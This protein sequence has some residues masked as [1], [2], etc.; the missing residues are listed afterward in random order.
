VKASELNEIV[1]KHG[2]WLLGEVGGT[3]ADLTGADLRGA[4]L[5]GADLRGAVL[6]G[7]VLRGADL[8]G[9]VLTRADLTGADLRGAD[10][11]GAVLTRAVL[12]RADLTG[13]DLTGADLTGADLRGADLRGAVLTRADL[14]G[15]DLRG[16]VLRGA[17]LT[18]A[19]LR[20]AD[21]NKGIPK[22]EKLHTKIA[23]A[24]EAGGKLE[25]GMWHT[26][27]TT[28]CRAGWAIHIAGEFGC[29]LEWSVGSAAAGALL[30][31]VA[32]PDQRVPD[33]YADNEAALEDIKR[34]AAEEALK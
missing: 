27:E 30:F 33:F 4:V 34:C 16:A 5:R 28:H 23:A 31:A 26:C 25:M 32:Y 6:R 19:D 13:A 1:R 21:L 10:L 7:A 22:I 3:R 24:I 18:G 12:T 2:C 29:G 20:G 15:A 9:A 11:R 17:D 14:T 8:T